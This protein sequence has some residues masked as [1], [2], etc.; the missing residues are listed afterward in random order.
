[1]KKSCFAADVESDNWSCG[2][3]VE[4]TLQYV[5]LDSVM[6]LPYY[7]TQRLTRAFAHDTTQHLRTFQTPRMGGRA[8]RKALKTGICV[9][10][11]A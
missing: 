7:D 6:V 11:T 5:P 9:S 10:A 4:K 2:S 1:M 8:F 3:T